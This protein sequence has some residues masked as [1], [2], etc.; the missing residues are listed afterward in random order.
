MVFV[1][2]KLVF[3][4]SILASFL[5]TSYDTVECADFF[6]VL[7]HLYNHLVALQYSASNSPTT[8]SPL[9]SLLLR[10]EEY[11]EVVKM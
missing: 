4:S 7:R 8:P 5:Q 10:E 11:G 3:V 1:G 9:P 6:V 2:P